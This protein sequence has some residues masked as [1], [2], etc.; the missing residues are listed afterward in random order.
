MSSLSEILSLSN[1]V[2]KAYCGSAVLL[3][4]KSFLTNFWILSLKLRNKVIMAPEDKILMSDAATPKTGFGVD[5]PDVKRGYAVLQNDFE[6]FI[7]FY[8]LGG[9]YVVLGGSAT[10]PFIVFPAGRYAHSFLYGAGIPGLRILGFFAG[11]ASTVFLLYDIGQKT[12]PY[13]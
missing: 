13:W 5:H 6:N 7:Q 4:I 10:W 12:I 8:V 9:I 11:F 2:F 1:P 3:G